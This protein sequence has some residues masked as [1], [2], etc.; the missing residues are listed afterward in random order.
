MLPAINFILLS[1]SITTVSAYNNGVAANPPMGW[2]TWYASY[3]YMCSF[4]F[5]ITVI[6]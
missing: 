3:E 6:L 2:S 5:A 1:L 4:I